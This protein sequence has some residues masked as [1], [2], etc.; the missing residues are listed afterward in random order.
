MDG[1][2]RA[3][4]L[5]RVIRVLNPPTQIQIKRPEVTISP[6]FWPKYASLAG[7]GVSYNMHSISQPKLEEAVSPRS[8]RKYVADVMKTGSLKLPPADF[9]SR[10][11]KLERARERHRALL[12]KRNEEDQRTQTQLRARKQS[13]SDQFLEHLRQVAE[14]PESLRYVNDP[15]K[16]KDRYRVRIAHKHLRFTTAWAHPGRLRTLCVPFRGIISRPYNV[17]KLQLRPE[18]SRMAPIQ[19]LSATARTLPLK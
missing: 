1:S 5:L 18:P 13:E 12:E 15:T 3:E 8:A 17:L 11:L 19:R 7:T 10:S 2:P 4:D 6:G 9:I 14:C 16:D